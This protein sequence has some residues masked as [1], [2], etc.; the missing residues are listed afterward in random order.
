MRLI[1]VVIP[2]GKKDE[3][4]DLLTEKGIDYVISPETSQR[5][6]S[7]VLF[8]PIP[9]EGVEEILDELRKSGLEENGF[10]VV[11]KAEAIVA[12]EFEELKERYQESEEVD[13]SKVARQELK[14]SAESLSPSSPTYYLLLLAASLIASAGILLDNAAIVV[15]SMVI[16]PLIGPAMA[17]CV[18]TI[19]NDESLFYLG[20]K[21]QILGVLL[22]VASSIAFSRVALSIMLPANLDLLSLSQV[23]HQMNP[24]FL[25][26]IVALGSGLAGAFSLTA[27]IN[28][29]LVGVMIS[30]ALL[31]PA[32]AAGIGIA[33]VNLEIAV[34]ASII[35]LINLVSINLAGTFTLWFQGYKPGRWYEQKGAEKATKSR[36]FVLLAL[37]LVIAAFLG[38]MT[39]EVRRESQRVTKLREITK[40]AM[41]EAGVELT[42][43]SSEKTGLFFQKIVGISAEYRARTF[44]ESLVST[45]DEKLESYLGRSV[46]LSLGFRK[47]S[48]G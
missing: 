23:T 17:S 8:F 18:G 3:I 1:Q 29:A 44:K 39:W 47:V 10:T 6:Y 36:I 16:A 48:T 26:L 37:L 28:S 34:S 35:L 22:A 32:A 42:E 21:K 5:K 41:A 33:T 13:E 30:V 20:V 2:E 38:T 45:I 40:S 15:G 24:G 11:T 7:D 14:A 27:G 31:P 4:I 19:I 25:S 46:D 9:K 12:R 43:F